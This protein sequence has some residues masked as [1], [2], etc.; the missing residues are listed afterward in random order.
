M[1]KKDMLK[2]VSLLFHL[3]S[4]ETYIRECSVGSL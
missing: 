2:A 4:K 3:Q 1:I